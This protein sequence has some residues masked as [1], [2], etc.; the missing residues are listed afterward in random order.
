MKEVQEKNKII[1][2]KKTENGSALLELL[3]YISLFVKGAS[4]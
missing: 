2:N 1:L 3:F 4:F